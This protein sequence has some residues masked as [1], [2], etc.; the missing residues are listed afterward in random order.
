[1]NMKKPCSTTPLVSTIERP[2][3]PPEKR[4]LHPCVEDLPAAL[5]VGSG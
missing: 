4:L 3:L 1:M 2:A 5:A